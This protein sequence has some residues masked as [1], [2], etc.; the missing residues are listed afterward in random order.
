MCYL[1]ELEHEGKLASCSHS[2]FNVLQIYIFPTKYINN[3]ILFS[4]T[5]WRPI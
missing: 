1:L 5:S 2:E 4:F 3:L